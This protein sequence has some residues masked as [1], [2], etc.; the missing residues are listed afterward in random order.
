MSFR[1][2]QIQQ[3]VPS[4]QVHQQVPSGQVQQHVHIVPVLLFRSTSKDMVLVAPSQEVKNS[5]GT[6]DFATTTCLQDHLDMIIFWNICAV[7]EYVSSDILPNSLF[8]IFY[9][10][11]LFIADCDCA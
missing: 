1:S 6:W 5:H 10:C 2:S 7:L 11:L 8:R 9:I 4:G 3:Q